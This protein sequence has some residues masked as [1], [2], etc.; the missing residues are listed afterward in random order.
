MNNLE[1]Y[2]KELLEKGYCIIRNLLDKKN[3]E[4]LSRSIEQIYKKGITVHHRKSFQP[5]KSLI[6]SK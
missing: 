3:T 1:T 2:R 4:Q 6:H 5:I